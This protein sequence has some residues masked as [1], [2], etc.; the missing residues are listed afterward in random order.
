MKTFSQLGTEIGE[1]VERKNVAYG[2]SF[3]KAGAYLRL[4]YPD[5]LQPAQYD[6]A[7]LLVRDFDK[8]MRIATDG[9]A[10]GES[11]YAD[12][13]GYAILGAHMHQQRKAS[14]PWQGSASG[15]DAAKSSEPKQPA[16]AAQP[17]NATTAPSTNA[18]NAPE[19]SPQPDGYSVQ[20]TSAPAPGATEAASPS[21]EGRFEPNLRQLAVLDYLA[22]RSA[23]DA[24]AAEVDIAATLKIIGL[25]TIQ[26]GSSLNQ[27]QAAGYIKRTPA[28]L[29]AIASKGLDFIETNPFIERY[30]R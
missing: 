28:G 1:L 5:G 10:F 25:P 13:A 17:A 9:D 22:T 23:E 29:S 14:E 11:P 3:A 30:R 16:S 24:F 21:A 4:L 15:P 12:K 27:L 8:S 7:L 19:P 26:L 2:S 18:R 20:P 6:D